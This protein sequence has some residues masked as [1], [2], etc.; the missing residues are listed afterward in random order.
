MVDTLAPTLIAPTLDTIVNCDGL[1]NLAD[2]QSWLDNNAGADVTDLCGGSVD[3][4]HDYIAGGVPSF[5]CDN[6][7]T[8]RL[9]VTFTA[10]D[11]CSNTIQQ[12]ARFIVVDTSAPTITAVAQDTIVYCDGSDALP[13][14]QSWIDNNA[15]AIAIESCGSDVEWTT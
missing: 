11:N 4:M 15:G 5:S 9:T 1:G 7:T 2:L 13:D 10:S 14:L 12:T 3:W 6:D 8:N